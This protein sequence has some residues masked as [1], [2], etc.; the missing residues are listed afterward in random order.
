MKKFTKKSQTS[1]RSSQ[2]SLSLSRVDLAVVASTH[3]S[4]IDLACKAHTQ[5]V[6]EELVR[7]LGVRFLKNVYT[8]MAEGSWSHPPDQVMVTHWL[9]LAPP[10]PVVVGGC[11]VWCGMV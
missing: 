11:T 3:S 4:A 2:Q 5:E 7:P 1:A 10:P 8:Y 9:L 6:T